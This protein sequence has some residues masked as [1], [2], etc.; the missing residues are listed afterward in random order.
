MGATCGP[1]CGRAADL[2][3]VSVVF[4]ALATRGGLTV[5]R[6][7]ARISRPEPRPASGTA[8]RSVRAV[9]KRG[10]R[11]TKR[12]VPAARAILEAAALP[13]VDQSV[14]GPSSRC[15]HQKGETT[16]PEE[17]NPTE[18]TRGARCG[19]GEG[20]ATRPRHAQAPRRAPAR[21][22][23]TPRPFAQFKSPRIGVRSKLPS[24]SPTGRSG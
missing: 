22:S 9:H 6:M 20:R 21:R 23:S 13:P 11:G 4:H 8:R 17:V 16:F 14:R 18:S 3:S 15:H 10:G 12:H 2:A 1:I 24:L 19:E 7:L 5:A